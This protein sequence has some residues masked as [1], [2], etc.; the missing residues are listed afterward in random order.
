VGRARGCAAGLPAGRGACLPA[1]GLAGRRGHRAGQPG[2]RLAAG[3]PVREVLY[4]AAGRPEM[5]VVGCRRRG[6]V[7]AA[8]LGSTGVDLARQAPRPV[9]VVRSEPRADQRP[10]AFVGHVVVGIDH[11]VQAPTVL[12]FGSAA[13]SGSR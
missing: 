5:F 10:G 1:P 9:V 13:R 12:E 2:A 3:G 6:S 4:G 11:S 8:L 7:A